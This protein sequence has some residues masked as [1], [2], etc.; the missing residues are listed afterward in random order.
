ME[1]KGLPMI[2][3]TAIE[4]DEEGTGLKSSLGFALSAN[5]SRVFCTYSTKLSIFMRHM[6]NLSSAIITC[7]NVLTPNPQ[8][9]A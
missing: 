9:N 3:I 4:G 7:T 2:G 1:G 8:R 5:L 6:R